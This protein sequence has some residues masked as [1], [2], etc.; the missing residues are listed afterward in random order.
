M[1]IKFT[2][3]GRRLANKL[4]LVRAYRNKRLETNGYPSIINIES[5]SLCNLKCPMCNRERGITR[6]LGNM[7]LD[8]Y[9]ALI[10]DIAGQTE[11]AVL[12]NG[13]E[14]LINKNIFEMI[15]YAT[16][17]GLN[18]MISTNAT[19]MSEEAGRALIESGLSI[20][21]IALDGTT[22]ETYESIRKG[23]D[24]DSVER[25]VM[26]IIGNKKKMGRK[27]PHIVLQFIE[28]ESNKHELR[29]FIDKWS[30]HNVQVF[31]KPSTAW[32]KDIGHMHTLHCDRIWF[33]NVV[34]SDARVVPCCKDFNG[35]FA[36]GSLKEER[37]YDIW[38]SA[39]MLETR[40]QNVDNPNEY[41]LCRDCNYNPP[42]KHGILTDFAQCAFDMTTLAY[43]L[44]RLG[45]KKRKQL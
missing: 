5:T 4:K 28:M 20:M 16:Q 9:K 29:D 44:Y 12:H 32:G 27:N 36:L 33:Q 21:I 17:K 10:D 37:F 35:D 1:I 30:R 2:K 42:R 31:I 43:L 41:S 3:S 39:A 22:K 38:N 7:D 11:L 15:E 18:T 13:G 8:V 26:S 14:P 40:R 24:F 25:N 6:K 34:L 19:L 45:Y 23:A